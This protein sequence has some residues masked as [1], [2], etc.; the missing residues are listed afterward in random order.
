MRQIVIALAA[1]VALVGL[2]SPA[3]ALS[4]ATC[5]MLSQISEMTG[6]SIDGVVAANCGK[7][8]AG[9]SGGSPNPTVATSEP[10]VALG[11]GLGLIGAGLLR[12]RR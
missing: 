5:S 8:A 4:Q 2:A 10:L 1:V 9:P 12:R 6:G 7:P 11:V 3:M